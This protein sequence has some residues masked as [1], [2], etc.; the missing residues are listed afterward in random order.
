MRAMVLWVMGCSLLHTSWFEYIAY[1]YA[2][3]GFHDVRLLNM[4]TPHLGYASLD[5][6][7]ARV[8]SQIDASTNT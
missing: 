8:T 5:S 1:H 3:D 7:T 2:V 4:V 6:L